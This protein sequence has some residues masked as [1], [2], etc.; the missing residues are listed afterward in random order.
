MRGRCAGSGMPSIG[1]TSIR[2]WNRRPGGRPGCSI[3]NGGPGS[4]SVS[5][6]GG[7]ASLTIEVLGGDE[8]SSELPDLHRGNLPHAASYR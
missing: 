3:R 7:G 2:R 4:S 8:G 1:G 6:A 5:P